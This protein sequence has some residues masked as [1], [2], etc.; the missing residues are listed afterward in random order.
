M[1]SP[2][3]TAHCL[4]DYGTYQIQYG[5]PTGFDLLRDA[6]MI[7]EDKDLAVLGSRVD[8]ALHGTSPDL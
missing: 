4:H 3:W 8:R 1:G 7:C 2:L 6:S 5:M